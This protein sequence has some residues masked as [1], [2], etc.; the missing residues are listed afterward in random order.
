MLS[1]VRETKTEEVHSGLRR[2][3]Q[4]LRCQRP[5]RE[6]L[7]EEIL[8]RLVS[9][10]PARRREF[11]LT[12]LPSSFLTTAKDADQDI[13]SLITAS[14][15]PTENPTEAFSN[16]QR[17]KPRKL[18]MITL[19]RPMTREKAECIL[20]GSEIVYKNGMRGRKEMKKDEIT[21]M[22]RFDYQTHVN[23]SM[24]YIKPGLFT[25]SVDEV[26]CD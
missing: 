26:V 17:Y 19:P 16:P 5:S 18:G 9:A 7:W 13:Q 3:L 22:I 20:L 10:P 11:D 8:Q 12:A 6:C 24:D 14:K 25:W 4:V 23:V 1:D 2:G 15:L 21:D